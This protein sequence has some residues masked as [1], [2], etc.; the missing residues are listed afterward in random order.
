MPG[1]ALLLERTPARPCSVWS[2]LVI[3][4]CATARQL[5]PVVPLGSDA[6]VVFGDPIWLVTVLNPGSPKLSALLILLLIEDCDPGF[7]V[8]PLPVA[9]PLV[10]PFDDPPDV[11]ADALAVPEPE[12]APVPVTPPFGVDTP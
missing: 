6:D 7:A 8:L 11:P 12:L 9:E 3:V 5:P 4:V 10:E 2:E 1:E